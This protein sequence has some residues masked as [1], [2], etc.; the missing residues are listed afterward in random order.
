[1]LD[2]VY[3][4]I[5]P[6]DDLPFYVGITNNPNERMMQHLLRDDSNEGKVARIKDIQAGGLTPKMHIIEVVEG[7]SIAHEKETYWIQQYLAKGIK[8]T[9]IQKNTAGSLLFYT[10]AVIT[11]LSNPTLPVDNDP[12][13]DKFDCFGHG[14]IFIATK[15]DGSQKTR[16][17]RRIQLLKYAGYIAYPKVYKIRDDNYINLAMLE[18]DGYTDVCCPGCSKI[19]GKLYPVVTRNSLD[20]MR[21]NAA[22]HTCPEYVISICGGRHKPNIHSIHDVTF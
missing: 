4:L 14:L 6:R 13:W 18:Q 5:D 9:N 15:C 11:S 21:S 2:F 12:L 8:L 22:D 10:D 20:L 7:R 16:S 1:M 19:F 17:E 3:D